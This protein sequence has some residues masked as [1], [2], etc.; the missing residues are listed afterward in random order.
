MG[1]IALERFYDDDDLQARY[2]VKVIE[3]RNW[4]KNEYDQEYDD[5][6][7]LSQVKGIVRGEIQIEILEQLVANEMEGE[8]TNMQLQRER[9]YVQDL[10][11]NLRMHLRQLRPESQNINHSVSKD[12]KEFA[13]KILTKELNAED[14]EDSDD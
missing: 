12:F 14:D 13:L 7:M 4:L 11:K 8:Q 9:K 6:I 10:R 3:L 5:V 1:E 2:E